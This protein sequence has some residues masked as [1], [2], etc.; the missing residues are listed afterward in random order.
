MARWFQSV[1]AQQLHLK[2]PTASPHQALIP[3]PGT[4]PA[5]PALQGGPS[6][7]GPPGKSLDLLLIN[8]TQQKG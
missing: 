2:G 8:I 7:A 1:Q 5:F 3:Q 6:A 4:E